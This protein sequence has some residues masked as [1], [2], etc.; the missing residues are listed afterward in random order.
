[1]YG[2]DPGYLGSLRSSVQKT[3]ERS[4]VS[5][6]LVSPDEFVLTP[7]KPSQRKMRRLMAPIE[8]RRV[9]EPGGDPKR[10]EGLGVGGDARGSL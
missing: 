6:A 7:S 4:D 3:M 9:R 1:M 10:R 8:T 5:I 2:E